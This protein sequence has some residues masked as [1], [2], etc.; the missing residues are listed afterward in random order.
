MHRFDP[1]SEAA[2]RLKILLLEPL[3]PTVAAWGQV[4]SLQGF[5]IP[6]GV[7][8]VYQWLRHRGYDVDFIDTQFG[9]TTEQSLKEC[10]HRERYDVVGMSVYT[11]TADFAF[12]TARLV[13]EVLPQSKIVMDTLR[14]S[15]SSTDRIT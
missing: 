13:K 10:L 8:S 15:A 3:Y 5:N 2:K 11:P 7:L 12:Q 9:D 4:K 14:G 6:I 1:L